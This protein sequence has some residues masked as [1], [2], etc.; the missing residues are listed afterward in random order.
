[1]REL[2]EYGTMY[3]GGCKLAALALVVVYVTIL[4]VLYGTM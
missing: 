4:V 2:V 3:Q 1:L